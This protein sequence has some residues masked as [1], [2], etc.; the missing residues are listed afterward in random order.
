MVDVTPL[1]RTDLSY[2]Q[3]IAHM[4]A[5]GVRGV[6]EGSFMRMTGAGR[7]AVQATALAS[8][9]VAGGA[10]SI[11]AQAQNQQIQQC[12]YEKRGNSVH[13]RASA[14]YGGVASYNA[15]EYIIA[16][17][18]DVVRLS[19]TLTASAEANENPKSSI[20]FLA[21]D[22]DEASLHDLYE[23]LDPPDPLP[24]ERFRI[25]DEVNTVLLDWRR[26][27]HPAIRQQPSPLIVAE[28][29]SR[30]EQSM[31]GGK[32]FWIE[33]TVRGGVSKQRVRS[34]KLARAFFDARVMA[35]DLVARAHDGRCT[36]VP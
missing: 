19:L 3:Q 35:N 22:S 17:H 34:L 1:Y 29:G 15:T 13:S 24:I 9:L 2:A 33:V 14:R 4:R 31:L 18:S 20:S 25:V 10:P 27:Q 32:P 12:M 28:P 36:L 6:A 16:P 21:E 7:H 5:N 11:T 23:E 30:L 8:L 26:D